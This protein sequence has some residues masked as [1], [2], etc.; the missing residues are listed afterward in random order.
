MVGP[1]G[2]SLSVS[3]LEDAGD[4][5]NTTETNNEGD[6]YG[7]GAS[8]GEGNGLGMP[9]LYPSKKKLQ[10]EVD[11]L[12]SQVGKSNRKVQVLKDKINAHKQEDHHGK[13]GGKGKNGGKGGPTNT[14]TTDTAVDQKLQND[15]DNKDQQRQTDH[16]IDMAVLGVAACAV[17]LFVYFASRG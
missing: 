8:D 12:R 6:P 13:G 9:K 2:Y 17:L 15:V 3:G 14:D 4:D 10:K 7:W 5:P 1:G 16:Q 11:K